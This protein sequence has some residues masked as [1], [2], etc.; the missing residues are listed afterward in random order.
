[1]SAEAEDD[2]EKFL[3]VWPGPRPVNLAAVGRRILL[4]V[5]LV[6]LLGLAWTGLS[7]GINQFPQSTTLG[8]KV[9]TIAQ[10]A[11][12]L[13]ALLIVITVFWSRGWRRRA[14]WGWVTSVTLAGGLASVVWG[15]TGILIG[16]L[17]GTASLLVA[18][19]I[20]WMLRQGLAT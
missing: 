11:Y 8:R 10:A 18:L 13:F 7:G 5:A 4:P 19:G 3:R 2:D 12:G 17:A 15:G 14:Q 6:C 20:I 9:Q 1:M 16:L